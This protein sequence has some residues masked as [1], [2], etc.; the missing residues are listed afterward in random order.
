MSG[1]NFMA[2]S[3][4]ALVARFLGQSLVAI[5]SECTSHTTPNIYRSI[6]PSTTTTTMRDTMTRFLLGLLF[7]QL[8]NVVNGAFRHL[9]ISEIMVAP[10]A[11]TDTTTR[12]FEIYNSGVDTVALNQIKLVVGGPRLSGVS[13]SMLNTT[14][15]ILLGGYVVIGNNANRAT[16]GNVKVDVVVNNALERWSTDG[17]G[18]NFLRITLPWRTLCLGAT[19][20]PVSLV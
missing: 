11:A 9:K 5:P 8:V 19:I 10:N 16:N 12:W 15:E 6:S 17:S 3:L 4:G 13:S 18:Y 14:H 2:Q 7:F 20:Y 1:L